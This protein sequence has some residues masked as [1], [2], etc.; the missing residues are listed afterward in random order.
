MSFD[1]WISIVISNLFHVTFEMEI[2]A[3]RAFVYLWTEPFEGTKRERLAECSVKRDPARYS[4]S[5]HPLKPSTPCVRWQIILI[6]RERSRRLVC[7]GRRHKYRS[8][9][10]WKRVPSGI[11]LISTNLILSQNSG[12]TLMNH[13]Y[14]TLFICNYYP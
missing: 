1:D 14:P 8:L 7:R 9:R 13:L 12:Y 2:Y 5:S 4:N 3:T 10:K 6:F 11:H